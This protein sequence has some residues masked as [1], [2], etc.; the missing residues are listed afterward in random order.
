MAVERVAGRGGGRSFP[1]GCVGFEPAGT[2]CTAQLAAGGKCLLC[3]RRGD[4]PVPV[5]W[6]GDCERDDLAGPS[7]QVVRLALPSLPWAVVA[8]VEGRFVDGRFPIIGARNADEAIDLA[9][10]RASQIK[11]G[12]IPERCGAHRWGVRGLIVL[13]GRVAAQS[14]KWGQF[15]GS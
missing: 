15:H 1:H 6:S 7:V 12:S 9:L 8:F 5:W 11:P 10:S 2:I 13:C 3:E 14:S 4:F